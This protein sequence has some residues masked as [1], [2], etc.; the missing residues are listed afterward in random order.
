MYYTLVIIKIKPISINQAW[1]GKRFKTPKYKQWRE[2]MGWL[3]GG[4]K[5]IEPPYRIKVTFGV[6]SRTDID[7]PIKPLFDALQDANIITNDRY[8]EE[9]HVY[10][11]KVKKGEEF[12]EFEVL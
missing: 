4:C 2:E 6:D 10:K 5:P 11:K 12:I 7:N 1:C 3:L 8:I 9:L